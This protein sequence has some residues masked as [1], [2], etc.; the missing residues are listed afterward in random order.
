L[1]G[2]ARFAI[3]GAAVGYAAQVGGGNPVLAFLGQEVIGDAKKAFD[4]DG[5]AYFF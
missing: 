2:L 1:A 3:F 5:Y 4:G